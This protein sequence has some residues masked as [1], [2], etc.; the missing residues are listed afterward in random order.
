MMI[1]RFHAMEKN[2]ANGFW[3]IRTIEFSKIQYYSMERI[4]M[5]SNFSSA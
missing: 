1:V 2:L 5:L 3:Q 4:S